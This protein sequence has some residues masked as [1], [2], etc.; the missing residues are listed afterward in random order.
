MM[1]YH[2]L[3]R[4][5]RLVIDMFTI[6]IVLSVITLS[7]LQNDYHDEKAISVEDI[8]HYNSLYPTEDR[9]Q[10]QDQTQD[11]GKSTINKFSCVSGEALSMEI[12]RN[13]KIQILLI[14]FIDKYAYVFSWFEVFRF[15]YEVNITH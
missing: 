8:L 14:M 15:D 5:I 3:W 13:W 2:K 6:L 11:F 9:G 7:K 4:P 10:P 1:K 12:M